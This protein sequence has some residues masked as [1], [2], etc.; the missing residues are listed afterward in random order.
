MQ[1]YTQEP[2]V[3]WD[4][5]KSWANIR[6]YKVSFEEAA[7]VLEHSLSVTKHDPDHSITESRYLTLGLS[8]KQRLILVAHTEDTVE[9]RII[10]ARLPT[11][12]ER[13][14]YENE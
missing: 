11:R 6:K 8:F 5:R 1:E 14:A 2:N 12:S 7:T 3:R 10:S 13:N 9:I 4:P